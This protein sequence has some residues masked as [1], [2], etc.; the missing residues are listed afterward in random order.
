LIREKSKFLKKQIGL[1]KSELNSLL[2]FNQKGISTTDL[3]SQTIEFLSSYDHS[4]KSIMT[5]KL[6]NEFQNEVQLK[7]KG[8]PM[9][10]FY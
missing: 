5:I 4:E 10:S 8:K 3:L 1:L 9:K 6:M 2:N 7:I